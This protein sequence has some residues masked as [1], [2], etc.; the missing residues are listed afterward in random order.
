VILMFRLLSAR[1]S[2]INGG[3][4]QFGCAPLCTKQTIMDSQ[5][6]QQDADPQRQAWREARRH[7]SR[8]L[9]LPDVA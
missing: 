8:A 2:S 5:Q 4:W 1:Y 9:L 6:E 3:H 7:I